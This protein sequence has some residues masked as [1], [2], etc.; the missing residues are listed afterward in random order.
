MTL[1][2]VAYYTFMVAPFLVY[3]VIFTLQW[4]AYRRHGHLSFLILSSAT[5]CGFL[6]LTVPIATRWWNGAGMPVSSTWY[7]ILAFVLLAQ[8]VLS[9]WGT[10]S[11]FRS[12]G[13]LAAA[14]RAAT[15]G[16]EAPNNRWRGP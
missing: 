2:A 14:A 1:G 16:A 15:A 6:F 7:A 10:A 12:Y 5:I 11:L 13:M 9:V 3:F 8:C 4:G